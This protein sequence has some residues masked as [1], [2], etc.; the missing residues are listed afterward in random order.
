MKSIAIDV[1]TFTYTEA[2]LN[3]YSMVWLIV[4]K[5]VLVTASFFFTGSL[6]HFSDLLFPSLKPCVVKLLLGKRSAEL[7][8]SSPTVQ[9]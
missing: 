5:R 2:F 3:S 6:A 9:V 1:S 4:D 7:L 8:L